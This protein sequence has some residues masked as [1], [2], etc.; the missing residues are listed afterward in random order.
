ML[1][2]NNSQPFSSHQSISRKW[3]LSAC[4]LSDLPGLAARRHMGFSSMRPVLLN[5]S[6]GYPA[7]LPIPFQS[8]SVMHAFL[9][10]TWIQ[11][12]PAQRG[13]E[14]RLLF[15]LTRNI[16]CTVGRY[17]L[18][19]TFPRVSHLFIAYSPDTVP[20]STVCLTLSSV[21]RRGVC[22]CF[23]SFFFFLCGPFLRSSLNFLQY[24]FWFMF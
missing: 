22:F 1:G 20:T 16:F 18:P 21:D 7:P 4:W 24:C 13:V 23:L 15:A 6:L 2:P 8:V 10:K 3:W 17:L 9:G 5:W 12:I 11:I 19:G 14:S